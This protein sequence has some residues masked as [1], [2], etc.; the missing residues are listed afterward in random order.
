MR[1]HQALPIPLTRTRPISEAI[2]SAGGVRLSQVDENLQ[3]GALPGVFVAGEMLDWEAT[4]GGYLLS[5]C[6]ALGR[7]AGHGVAQHLKIET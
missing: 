3:L 4:T 5:A 1:R 2:S 7:L 6:F